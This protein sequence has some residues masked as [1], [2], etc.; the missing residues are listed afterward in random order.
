MLKGTGTDPVPGPVL[1]GDGTFPTTRETQLPAVALGKGTPSRGGWQCHGSLV[2]GSA[3]PAICSGLTPAPTARLAPGG[4]ARSRTPRPRAP[5]ALVRTEAGTAQAEQPA[6]AGPRG[7]GRH[8]QDL[9]AGEGKGK[10]EHDGV[11]G[12]WG[13]SWG[14]D[15]AASCWIRPS[16][17][18][19]VRAGEV[20]LSCFCLLSRRCCSQSSALRH[21][22][23]CC[24]D[25]SA[26][27]GMGQNP[28]VWMLSFALPSTRSRVPFEH[29]TQALQQK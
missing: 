29:P 3:A 11:G 26:G 22:L 5:A 14:P 25:R 27:R 7:L 23:R 17:A 16:A 8:G 2:P 20:M 15:A 4:H 1:G 18:G 10:S 24:R 9:Q 19:R 21:C 6:G 12:S 13:T 28:Q